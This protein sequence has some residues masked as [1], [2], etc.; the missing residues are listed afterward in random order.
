MERSDV[1]FIP[2]KIEPFNVLPTKMA[3]KPKG[4]TGSSPAPIAIVLPLPCLHITKMNK[5]SI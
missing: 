5:P 1:A 4:T 3:R 2:P